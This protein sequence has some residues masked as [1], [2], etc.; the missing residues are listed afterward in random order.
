MAIPRILMAA[1][2]SSTFI[3]LSG[4]AAPQ[5]QLMKMDISQVN[6]RHLQTRAFDTTDEKKTLRTVI[7]TLQ[8]F[9]FLIDEANRVLGLVSATR[10]VDWL[11]ITVTVRA[12][13]EGQM[14]V[15]ANMEYSRK[16]V[17]DPSVYRQFFTYLEKSMFLTAH[18][19]D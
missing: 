12:N 6:L 15:R 5:K 16:G 10:S 3:G 8:D 9:D 11:Q 13:S 17:E 4:C 7:S 2:A 14:L 1:I 19:V 18:A